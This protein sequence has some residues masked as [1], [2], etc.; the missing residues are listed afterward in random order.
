LATESTAVK[1]PPTEVKPE[2]GLTPKAF[3]VGIVISALI[4][5]PLIYWRR[6]Q[7]ARMFLR[8]MNALGQVYTLMLEL[9]FI[10][11]ILQMAS[12]AFKFN[13]KELTVVYA[14]LAVA[15][16]IPWAVGCQTFSIVYSGY[17]GGRTVLL[18]VIPDF[19]TPKDP[20][21]LSKL[22]S[23][24]IA[25]DVGVWAPSIMTWTV[26]Y[27]LFFFFAYAIGLILRKPFL[28]VE[29]LPFP[30]RQPIS[31]MI[32]NTATPASGEPTAN[33][34]RAKLL[35]KKA[36]AFW[37]A[38]IIGFFANW[39]YSPTGGGGQ[40]LGME[41]L[42]PGWP[43]PEP[44]LRY[45]YLSG[46]LPYPYTNI[47]MAWDIDA[48]GIGMYF[49]FPLD[50][51]LTAFIWHVVGYIIYPI[52]AV[53][54]GIV[55][56]RPGAGEWSAIGIGTTPPFMPLQ[57]GD[58]G[59]YVG[60]AL[61]ALFMGRKEIAASFRAFLKGP[62]K[63]ELASEPVSYRT[64]WSI[65]IVTLVGLTLFLTVSGANILLALFT[66]LLIG[67][68]QIWMARVR[69][70]AW[71]GYSNAWATHTGDYFGSWITGFGQLVGAFPADGVKLSA[72]AQRGLYVTAGFAGLSYV[73]SLW[74]PSFACIETFAVAQETKTSLKEI[75]LATIP[76][77][78]IVMP[79]TFT[80]LTM[81][82]TTFGVQHFVGDWWTGSEFPQINDFII[83]RFSGLSP[84]GGGN[85]GWFTGYT[86]VGIILAFGMGL[87]RMTLPWF[88][89]NP[90]GLVMMNV[91]FY[92]F[93]YV[94]IAYFS[95]LVILK[96]GGSELYQ[97]TALPIAFGL[98]VGG[99]TG[100]YPIRALVH[101]LL[102]R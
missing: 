17:M 36:L 68:V 4:T 88:P 24:N 5:I 12:K 16:A 70:E 25:F 21:I 44:Y 74:S 15:T 30:M 90:I 45:T 62:T 20:F 82:L 11:A 58:R 69:A 75:F 92:G 87:A 29:K 54:T 76:V 37:I 80:F 51:L 33:K 47:V 26:A 38:F 43:E 49:L 67:F 81:N 52:L 28:E 18:P 91:S 7:W 95:K 102:W 84:Y 73:K 101:F 59:A 40:G 98:M 50:I 83:P 61:F 8:R 63:E 31:W 2:K 57:I 13:R 78:L 35:S 6:Y 39:Y 27:Y 9:V 19:W 65:L 22:W 14:M 64:S 72:E 42:I 60:I 100:F 56:A 97:N 79:L 53:M 93:L 10:I 77:V 41:V 66:V 32:D 1:A 94:I 86:I 55:P 46:K 3:T 96:V 23:G 89:L 99:F 48:F 85:A 34:F 71:P